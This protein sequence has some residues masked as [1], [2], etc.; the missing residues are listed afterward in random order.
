LR[1]SPP[2]AQPQASAVPFL[3]KDARDP[4]CGMMVNVGGAKYKS[5]HQGSPVYFCCAGCKQAF[6]RQPD[7]Y[8][9]SISV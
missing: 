2:I 4:V 6:D 7:K 1:W 8:A 5:E 3:Q 9:A